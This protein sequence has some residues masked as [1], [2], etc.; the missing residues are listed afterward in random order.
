MRRLPLPFAFLLPCVGL[1]VSIT[2]LAVP[3]TLFYFSLQQLAHGGSV[4][5]LHLGQFGAQIRSEHFLSFAF[6]STALR[7]GHIVD[8]LNIPGV[9]GEGLMS[10]IKSRP[11][12]FVPSG[13]T[14]ESWRAISLP[15]FCLPAWWLVGRGLDALTGRRRAHWALCLIGTL[16]GLGFSVLALGLRFGVEAADRMDETWPFWGMGLW[17]VLFGLLP[18][19]WWR[20]WRASPRI[21]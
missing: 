20:Q 15:V 12:N 6:M 17:V 8:A 2:I 13:M 3:T 9:L 4:A 1:I 21:P 14:L 7:F 18:V 10:A 11:H 5:Y 16:L 19:A